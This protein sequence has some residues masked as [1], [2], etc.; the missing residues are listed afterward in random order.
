[1]K[2][3]KKSNYLGLNL[4]EG[5]DKVD[6]QTF[7]TDNYNKIDSSLADKVTQIDINNSIAP[8]ADKSY[9]DTQLTTKA[10]QADV[11]TINNTLSQKAN[12]SD[13]DV[14]TSRINS[15]TALAA[16]STTGDAELIDA[17]IGADGITYTNVGSAIRKQ[18][19]DI[20]SELNAVI[21]G[22]NIVTKLSDVAL[23]TGYINKNGDLSADSSWRYGYIKTY[24]LAKSI[25]VVA[26]GLSNT[27]I[28]NTV[29]ANKKRISNIVEWA[30]SGTYNITLTDSIKYL[31]ISSQSVDTSKIVVNENMDS[32]YDTVGKI[33]NNVED[34]T[35]NISNLTSMVVGGQ[36]D[37]PLSKEMLTTGAYVNK[38]GQTYPMSD[39]SYAYVDIDGAKSVTITTNGTTLDNASVYAFFTDENHNFLNLI[40]EWSNLANDIVFDDGKI[41]GNAK[42]ICISCK[43]NHVP[44]IHILKTYGNKIPSDIVKLNTNS[45]NLMTKSVRYDS[46][47]A[48]MR[49]HNAKFIKG[50]H[51]DCG[52]KYFSVANIKTLLDNAKS[53]GLNTFQI[54]FSDNQGFRFALDDMSLNVYG[55]TYDLSNAL[56]SLNGGGDGSN[57][58]L[59]QSE[60]TDIITYANNK[61][62]EVIP[63][64][65][66]PGHWGLNSV[67]NKFVPTTDYG[68]KAMIEILKKYASY[69]AS[70]GCRYYN[71]CGDESGYSS[72]VYENFMS[73]AIPEIV[74]LGMTPML[75]NDMV[76]KNG[77]LDPYINTGAI[78]LGWSSNNNSASYSTVEN[79]GY[80]ILNSNGNIYYWVLG[81]TTTTPEL[82]SKIRNSN[83]FKLSDNTISYDTYGA[84]YH[85]WCDHASA[86]G[87]DGGTNVVAQ[88][89]SCISA[90]GEAVNREVPSDNLMITK[91][92][93][94]TAYRIEVNN[95]GVLSAT[96]LPT[97]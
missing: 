40:V 37:A 77:Y 28:I 81:G 16:G 61:G 41:W 7:F 35:F 89:A 45:N 15:F 62:I 3:V 86:D 51:L 83:V 90:F 9:V 27:I 24:G 69:F 20:R 8:K 82:V 5:T 6:Y 68:C 63:A 31:C 12:K 95:L 4:P 44:Y 91:S 36:V 14:Q 25:S 85:I 11:N 2:I 97:T 78:V 49:T 1:V 43:T 23:N 76:C 13:L 55:D 56:G 38:N 58:Y 84:M 70:K 19:T 66:M 88:T 59:T 96:A 39:Y 18:I 33:D 64:F 46:P 71:I 42:Y 72:E 52:R 94:G 80:K 92:P 93:N 17:R 87:A 30:G 74:L 29:D 57:S 47:L 22:G 65:D 26:T 73:L 50:L 10:N 48:A 32:M 53:A 21:D 67:F 54:Y 60:M 79:C 34:H 75:Y